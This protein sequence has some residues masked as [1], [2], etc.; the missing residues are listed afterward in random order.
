MVVLHLAAAT[1]PILAASLSKMRRLHQVLRARRHQELLAIVQAIG[2]A[3]AAAA[4]V[5]G[6][7]TLCLASVSH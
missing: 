4:R 7:K 3:L 2:F 5:L 6:Q 1:L